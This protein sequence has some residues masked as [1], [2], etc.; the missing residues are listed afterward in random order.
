[1]SD[2]RKDLENLINHHSQENGC[3]TPDYILADY[4]CNCL[5]AFDT[6]V[7]YRERWHGRSEGWR[8]PIQ[9]S[10]MNWVAPPAD[11][12]PVEISSDMRG[13]EK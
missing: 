9:P 6:A 12:G 4:L 2:F 10:G 11:L 7:N 3:N 1:M 8:A 5:L 13:A